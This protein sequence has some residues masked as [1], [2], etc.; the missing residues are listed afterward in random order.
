MGL[1]RAADLSPRDV[2]ALQA[3]L[4]LAHQGWAGCDQAIRRHGDVRPFTRIRAGERSR[5]HSFWR[6]FVRH[7][8]PV[9]PIPRGE[10]I[11]APD[12]LAEACNQAGEQERLR[13]RRLRQLVSL[14]QDE[15]LQAALRGQL[16]ASEARHLLAYE[17][18]GQCR[19]TQT[20]GCPDGPS[21]PAS[22]PP[23]RCV[24]RS[25]QDWLWTE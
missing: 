4:S 6:L 12:S 23:R 20:G 16:E 22:A 21:R 5:I 11:Q 13:L 15:E 2:E 24:A 25:H 3:A 7:G 1:T 18:C 8:L 19:N 14:V 17:R 10:P 9:P